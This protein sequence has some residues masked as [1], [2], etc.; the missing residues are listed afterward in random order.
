MNQDLRDYTRGRLRDLCAEMGQK[1]FH[2]DY[3]FSFIH[4]KG[5]GDVSEISSLSAAFRQKLADEGFGI[6]TIHCIQQQQD[7]DGTQKFLFEA[8][9]GR[10][11]ETVLMDDE[12]RL[13]ACVSCQSGCAM[14]CAFCATGQ[15]GFSRD[16]TAGE[17]AWQV[18]YLSRHF[19][20]VSNVVYMGMGEPFDNYDAVMASVGILM[21]EKGL[22]LGQRHITVSTVGLIPG[23]EKF[24]QEDWQVRLA[25]SLHSA[26]AATRERLVPAAKTYPLDELIAAL[27]AY[28]QKSGRRVTI[29][30]CMIDRVND[31]DRDAAALARLVSGL[32]CL[33]NLIELNPYPG[34]SF[35]PSSHNRIR[36]FAEVLKSKNVETA[37]RYRRGR[38]ISA[39]CGQLGAER[40][41]QDT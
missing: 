12:G 30:Y 38:E 10:L 5:A 23:I 32:K 9:D 25:V 15:L 13:T 37:I 4:E 7:P 34:C 8:G 21:D 26:E 33:V 2:G 17:I 41:I 22:N 3:L 28:Q 36:A 27:R 19:K 16:L 18:E 20:R 6:G 29:E 24:T 31:G 1:K 40:L 11:F 14:K 39:A 35:S